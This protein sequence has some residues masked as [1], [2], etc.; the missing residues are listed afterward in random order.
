MEIDKKIKKNQHETNKI[1]IT[2]VKSNLINV[3]LLQRKCLPVL[4]NE[5]K[6][7]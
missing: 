1:K 6:C 4:K 5:P 2:T 7:S 3:M